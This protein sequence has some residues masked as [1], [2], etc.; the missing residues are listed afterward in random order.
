MIEIIHRKSEAL[1]SLQSNGKSLILSHIWSPI[2]ARIL[3]AK[4]YPTRAK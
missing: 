1:L 4:G 2:G 3:E